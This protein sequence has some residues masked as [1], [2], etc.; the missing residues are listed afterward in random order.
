MKGVGFDLGRELARRMGVPFEPVTYPSVGA[1]LDAGKTGAW[2]VAFVGFSPERAKEWNFTALHLEIE[3]GYLVPG[4][5]SIS[6]MADIDRPG[7][8]VAVQEKSQPDVFLSRTLKNAVVVRAPSL[9]GTLEVLKSGRADAI[10]SIKP[11]LFEA[12]NQLP[13]SR[14]LD[15]RAGVD[16]HAMAL[17]KD[18]DLGVA[19]ARQFIEAAKSEGLVQGAIERVGMRGAVVAPPEWCSVVD[20]LSEAAKPADLPIEHRPSSSW[21][22]IWKTTKQIGLTIP[23][24]VL[25]RAEQG[26]QVIGERKTMMT[27]F[28]GYT[29]CA[30]L[31]VS[32]YPVGAQEPKNIPRL[33]FLSAGASQDDKDRLAVFREGL[34]E[35]GYV[36]AKNILLEY[37]FA[38]GKLD[39]LPELA[40]G[41]ARLN[42]NIIV[43]AGNEAVQAAK[44]ATQTIPIVM[45]FSGDP[46]G[47]GFVTNLARPGGNITGLSRINIELTAKRLELLNET[48]PKATQ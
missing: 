38:D 37:R 15:G 18:R 32:S 25:A 1:L 9:A 2:D 3:F 27:R 4:G 46:V 24:N 10:F 36:E 12:S 40:A 28:A 13:G 44:N 7:I 31:C 35:L 43:T 5:S 22:S 39:R 19:Y 30:L 47:A 42:V 11:S 41:L 16:P 8:R 21:S 33:G 20:K 34:R 48:V 29:L 14:V 45:A 17:P 6:T 23:P 26:D